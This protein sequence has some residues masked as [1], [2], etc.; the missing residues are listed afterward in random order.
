MSTFPVT[1]LVRRVQSLV[2]A[3]FEVSE[4][5]ALT[6]ASEQVSLAEGWG[7][8]DKAAQ[9]DWTMLIKRNLGDKLPWKSDAERNEFQRRRK[10]SYDA[11]EF[12]IRRPDRA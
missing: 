8:P 7:S 5:D 10:E 9:L 3:V 6:Y 1:P 4:E 2:L 12:L 11:Y